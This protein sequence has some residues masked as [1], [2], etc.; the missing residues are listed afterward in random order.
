MSRA[1][2][3][4]N[5]YEPYDSD[6]SY[7]ESDQ[8]SDG[9][10][11]ED[12]R[13]RH[14]ED[15]R[16]AILRAPSQLIT[17]NSSN[18]PVAAG[19]PWDD[20]TNIRSL[21]EHVYLDPP[22][23]TKTSLV[24]IK[25]IDRDRSVFPTP[26][27]FRLKLP[28]VYKDVTKFQLVQMSFPNNANNIAATTLFTS[29]LVTILLDMGIP[30]TCI[31]TCVSVMNC[32]PASQAMGV[33]EQG[34]ITPAGE[35]L[36]GAI[37]IPHGNYTE[38][39]LANELNVQTN[40]TPPLNLISYSIFRDIFQ[41]TRD[42]SVLFNEPGDTYCSPINNIRYGGHTKENIM[43]TYYT[44]QH[45]D[46]LPNITDAIAFTAYYFPIL[47]EAVATG[48]SQ[49]FLQTGTLGYDDMVNAVMGPFQGLDSPLY[50]TLCQ[51]NQAPLDSYRRYLTFEVRN[52]NKYNWVYNPNERR[53]T[54]LHDSLNTS[55]QRDLSKQHQYIMDQ[56]LA[57]SNL[58]LYAFKTLKHELV[59][60]QSILAHLERNLSTV[61]G[62]YHLASNYSYS[63]G[64][65][66]VT[67][68]ST[69]SLDTLE[70]DSDFTSMFNYTS[71]IGRIFNNYTGMR[72][73]FTNFTDYHSTLSSYYSI[74]QSTTNVISSIHGT[75]RL[76]F[77]TYVSTKYNNVLPS[78]FIANQSYLSNQGI[79]VSFV[80]NQRLYI[81]GQGLRA[82]TYS[83]LQPASTETC[84]Q[85]CCNALHS[86]VNAW[87]ACVP[88]NT[89]IN[90]L[91]Y[92]L[93]LLNTTP[94]EFNVFSTIA[95]ITS[96]SNL[97]YLMQIND[98][99]GFNNM[100][101]T[102]PENYNISNEGTGQ[103]RFI[104]GKILMAEIGNTGVS[105]TV[106][107]NP[108]VFENALGKLDHLDFKIY[109][110]DEAMTPAWLYLP[111]F[112]SINE[113]NATF[114]IDEQ[115]GYVNQNLGWSNRPTVPVPTNPDSTPYLYYTHMDN[116]N[117]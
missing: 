70:Q 4:T 18:N 104:S 8:E 110:D 93:G 15:P 53:Y 74:V 27:R 66:H 2:N 39:Q 22:K 47:K 30:S 17:M 59:G 54:I 109:Y 35:P 14:E 29:S 67:N 97:N 10:D 89:V 113:W 60:Y 12:P 85:T 51:L 112:L 72:M 63:G 84:V 88:V 103:V 57:L 117:N 31:S 87:Y 9:T 69:F 33:L 98:E 13:I 91:N 73:S 62:T 75:V 80:T 58:D 108:T 44:Q 100:D 82:Q 38:S 11:T 49:P 90:S 102:M 111:Y 86:L 83:T 79:P 7:I 40:S 50:Y 48:R 78:S 61:L 25:S 106:I 68:E 115:I 105:Q 65:N 21:A 81:P 26:F 16:Y 20:S 92:R 107:Q 5:Y 34:R 42:I 28:R 114:Q 46:Q 56:E 36:L 96:T 41:H 71:T 64:C 77:H 99:Q 101:L 55:I 43:N 19:A 23:T 94:M 3:E 95:Q 24:S 32:S 1:R 116:P 6:E 37:T 45:I 76:D 52:V